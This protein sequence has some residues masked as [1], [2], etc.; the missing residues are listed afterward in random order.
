[1]I[2]DRVMRARPIMWL[3]NRLSFPTRLVHFYRRKVGA[4]VTVIHRSQRYCSTHVLHSQPT[5]LQAAYK[6]VGSSSLQANRSLHAHIGTGIALALALGTPISSLHNHHHSDIELDASNVCICRCIT[7]YSMSVCVIPYLPW[8]ISRT[9][10]SVDHQPARR[11]CLEPG[12]GDR[13][14]ETGDRRPRPQYIEQ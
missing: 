14:P 1:M 4:G 8:L 7:I 3:R 12:T 2:C 6:L 11:M 10:S 5:L 13:R 9:M